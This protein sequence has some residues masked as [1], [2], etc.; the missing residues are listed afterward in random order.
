MSLQSRFATSI[1]VGSATTKLL[2]PSTVPLL[3]GRLYHHHALAGLGAS[4]FAFRSF[5]EKLLY[6]VTRGKARG[7]TATLSIVVKRFHV[8]ITRTSHGIG[9]LAFPVSSLSATP[10]IY[11]FT[12]CYGQRF[13]T[14][15]TMLLIELQHPANQVL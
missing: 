12:E 1:K 15:A 2:S 11:R 3:R 6:S 10:G 8:T 4:R 13:P 9:F 14:G 7:F 5:A